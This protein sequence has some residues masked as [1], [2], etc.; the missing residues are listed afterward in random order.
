MDTVIN[1]REFKKFLI[2]N[3]IGSLILA[4][5]TAV[6][7]I[8]IGHSNEYTY[9]VYMTLFLVIIHSLISLLFIW[10]DSRYESF[11]RFSF[12]INTIFLIIVASFVTSV[13]DTWNIISNMTSGH[14]YVTYFYIAFASLHG[15]IL[16]KA[17]N[18]AKHIDIT[19]YLSYIFIALVVLLLQPTIYVSN[20][21]LTLGTLYFKFLSA[22]LVID[23]TLSI[24]VA[25]FYKLHRYQHPELYQASDPVAHKAISPW[26][27]FLI[28][29]IGMPF[30]FQLIMLT[31]VGLSYHR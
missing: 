13:F 15:N 10:D 17:L 29:F 6:I 27:W 3:F 23:G 12:F 5:L 31:V 11:S 1:F 14:L 24:L 28:I 7:T 22:A 30:I 25:I 4:A 16:S 9:R 20:P 26:V 21:L 2:W 19:V 18:R 8:F